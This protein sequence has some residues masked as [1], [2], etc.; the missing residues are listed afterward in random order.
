MRTNA[1]NLENER[2]IIFQKVK[3]L[4]KELRI[5]TDANMLMESVCN[6]IST[7]RYVNMP[8]PSQER[9]SCHIWCR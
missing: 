4:L 9:Q 2:A 5:T 7:E 3:H 6:Q 1:C 8:L